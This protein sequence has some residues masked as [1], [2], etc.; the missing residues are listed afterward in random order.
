[1][2]KVSTRRRRRRVASLAAFSPP[3]IRSFTNEKAND[4]DVGNAAATAEGRRRRMMVTHIVALK[5]ARVRHKGTERE[6]AVAVER[7]PLF[8][9]QKF[10]AALN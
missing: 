1:M 8:V 9:V 2:E 4:H 10:D 7:E 3:S 5:V 6:P